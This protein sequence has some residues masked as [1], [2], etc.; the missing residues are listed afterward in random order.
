MILRRLRLTSRISYRPRRTQ[1]CWRTSAS[2]SLS[3][4]TARAIRGRFF[5][6]GSGN[7]DLE[8]RPVLLAS[9]HVPIA[10]AAAGAQAVD[11]EFDRVGHVEF[12]EIG[13]A[14]ERDA[15]E[16]GKSGLREFAAGPRS[17]II[18]LVA[19]NDVERDLVDAGVLAAH[20]RCQLS[21]LYGSHQIAPT[22]VA[23]IEISASD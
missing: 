12:D 11:R 14:L 8:Q 17:A 10:G 20:G 5:L 4:T 1:G 21:K 6:P 16:A 22:G 19:E 2:L 18:L 3:S 23:G 7:L 13:N 15:H 9:E